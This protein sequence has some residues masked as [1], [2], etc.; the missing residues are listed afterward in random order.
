MV[1]GVQQNCLF[2]GGATKCEAMF[3]LYLILKLDCKDH[4]V[5]VITT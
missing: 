2:G 5:S 3:N 4:V 1:S